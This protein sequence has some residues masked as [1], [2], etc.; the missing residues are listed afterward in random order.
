MF[1]HLVRNNRNLGQDSSRVRTNDL[2]DVK[3][4]IQPLRL[5]SAAV[6]LSYKYIHL[7][8]VSKMALIQS[9]FILST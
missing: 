9:I 7:S 3:L 2:A 4:N 1:L 8:G 6:K 5:T